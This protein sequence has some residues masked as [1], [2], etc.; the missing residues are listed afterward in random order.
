MCSHQV[1]LTLRVGLNCSAQRSWVSNAASRVV[2]AMK[3]IML[4]CF[5]CW[6][7]CRFA[8]QSLFQ[9]HIHSVGFTLILTVTTWTGDSVFLKW[10]CFHMWVWQVCSVQFWKR[11]VGGFL[12][13]TW[14]HWFHLLCVSH[15]RGE[16]TL[17]LGTSVVLTLRRLYFSCEKSSPASECI[18]MWLML[19]ADVKCTC[20]CSV[21]TCE[22]AFVL[23][24][25][26]Q[27]WTCM[28]CCFL[29]CG[30]FLWTIL[31]GRKVGLIHHLP[32]A[33]VPSEELSTKRMGLVVFR[34]FHRSLLTR[35]V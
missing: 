30:Q 26:H 2:R 21:S 17:L 25:E 14:L 8:L 34:L 1:V 16:P 6:F 5:A 11:C 20:V 28:F 31:D 15:L 27:P 4:Q 35:E 29:T 10:C 32:T 7:A 22:W 12:P 33:A 13:R 23:R 3:H 19:C 18:V 9:V 24:L